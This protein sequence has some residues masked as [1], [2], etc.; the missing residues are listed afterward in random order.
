MAITI[1]EINPESITSVL[2]KLALKIKEN[3]LDIVFC[4]DYYLDI[5]ESDLITKLFKDISYVN[6]TRTD[7]YF[8]SALNEEVTII[9][10]DINNCIKFAKEFCN[11]HNIKYN[12]PDP[13]YDNG[14]IYCVCKD[15][16]KR[17]FIF[18]IF[19]NKYLNFDMAV[20]SLFNSLKKTYYELKLYDIKM[21]M[22]SQHSGHSNVY[23]FLKPS[24]I[25]AT[26]ELHISDKRY[27]RRICYDGLYFVEISCRKEADPA[28]KFFKKNIFPS[29]PEI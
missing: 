1:P 9:N 20:R 6:S 24:S 4:A 7:D 10:G 11:R 17:D 23:D 13:V 5:D 2:S 21:N 8:Y 16:T 22:V 26:I 29:L 14:S 28:S 15:S 19:N 27:I 12:F 18:D 25:A 3:L